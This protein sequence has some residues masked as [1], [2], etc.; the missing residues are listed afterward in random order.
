[1]TLPATIYGPTT[2]VERRVISI[3]YPS[4]YF[5]LYKLLAFLFNYKQ[6]NDSIGN[7]WPW[8]YF[9]SLIILGSFFVM[10][11]VLGVLSG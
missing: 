2:P 6:I 9:V 5:S 4:K 3:T 1:M 11:L 8:M 10:N 7:S